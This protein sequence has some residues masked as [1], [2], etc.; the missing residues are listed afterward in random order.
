MRLF[1]ILML[2][3]GGSLA[4][5]E[6]AKILK[7]VSAPV[8]KS[9][10]KVALSPGAI[11][12]IKIKSPSRTRYS[13]LVSGRQV[14]VTSDVIEVI[15]DCDPAPDRRAWSFGAD[16]G[17]LSGYGAGDYNGLVTAVPNPSNV[18]GLQDP[19]VTKVSG[20][21]GFVIRGVA[22]RFLSPLWRLQGGLGYRRQDFSYS[23]R[24]NPSLGAVDLASLT[25]YSKSFT[26]ERL[27]AGLGIGVLH[28]FG[29]FALG[30][31]LQADLLY[32]LSGSERL[33]VL[34][35][36][37]S[38][39]KNTPATVTAGPPDWDYEFS[40]RLEARFYGGL[41]FGSVNPDGALIL[42]AGYLW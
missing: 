25:S 7:A 22:E 35:P 26:S 34:V 23:A 24:P 6:C 8:R 3:F 27:Q 12:P 39:F 11:Y 19:L 10:E 1:F 30:Y 40:L 33:Q 17:F 42:G 41:V 36:S 16:F 20:G 29:L 5:A 38:F 9:H 21:E 4:A 37:G 14:L 28:R 13:L 2:M 15:A 32:N 18:G 31:S